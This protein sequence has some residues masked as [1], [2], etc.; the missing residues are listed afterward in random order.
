MSG[1]V[2]NG[3]AARRGLSPAALG[4]TI[5][6]HVGIAALVMAIPGVTDLVPPIGTIITYAVPADRPP[7][8]KPQPLPKAKVD[9]RPSVITTAK[10]DIVLPPTDTDFI[11]KTAILPDTGGIL[12]G[13]TGTTIVEPPIQPKLV[14]ARIDRRFADA[15]QPAYPP[16]MIRQEAEG[17]VTVRVSI[18]A[19][20]RVLDVALVEAAS[21]AFFEA[22]KRQA[23]SRWRFLPA[24][25]DGVP[26][27]SERVMTVH[28][29]LTE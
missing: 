16:A 17:S 10:P 8:P 18:G 15:F 14:D 9:H 19:D 13:G 29:R 28:F 24:T 6:V 12:P 1:T 22:T 2:Q 21:P 25:R 20:G 23:L 7:P 4:G 3:Y 26:V 11:I 27:A 5:A